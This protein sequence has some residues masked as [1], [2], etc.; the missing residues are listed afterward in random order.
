ELREAARLAPGNPA[1][2]NNL[3][4]ALHKKER[5]PEAAAEYREAI[6]LNDGLAIAHINLGRL[7]H[8][9]E[10]TREAI[11]ED[12]KARQIDP[13][14]IIPAPDKADAFGNGLVFDFAEPGRV[15]I[16]MRSV[17]LG[18]YVEWT[19]TSLLRNFEDPDFV[20]YL[21]IYFYRKGNWE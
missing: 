2:H 15:P 5:L 21:G 6:R 1:V 4:W 19:I 16:D 9:L 12:S 13:H 17:T 8:A 10:K 7:L 14:Y 3:G 11:A 18:E 20:P